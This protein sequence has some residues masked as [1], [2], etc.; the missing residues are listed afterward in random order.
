MIFVNRDV[1][2]FASFLEQVSAAARMRKCRSDWYSVRSGS[3]GVGNR[4][5]RGQLVQAAAAPGQL[6]P[7]NSEHAAMAQCLRG[8]RAEEFARTHI[9][10]TIERV[11]TEAD[12]WHAEP[13]ALANVAGRRALDACSYDRAAGGQP[14]L[15]SRSQ[16]NSIS[17]WLP[18]TCAA[19]VSTT[20]S[21]S[22]LPRHTDPTTGVTLSTTCFDITVCG[23]GSDIVPTAP[24]KLAARAVSVLACHA[25]IPS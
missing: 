7:V 8:G 19:T 25:G 21:R 3:S 24:G 6:V 22:G 15:T 16:P 18:M 17:N 9:T 20:W 10:G 12:D 13:T 23:E 11:W 5:A 14:C 2:Y 1:S 4:P